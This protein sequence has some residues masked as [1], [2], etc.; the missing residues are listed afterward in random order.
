MANLYDIPSKPAGEKI[1]ISHTGINV[2]SHL[3]EHH[4]GQGKTPMG[5]GFCCGYRLMDRTKAVR[6]HQKHWKTHCH[7]K[8]CIQPIWRQWGAKSSRPFHKKKITGI[9]TIM[10]SFNHILQAN[11]DTLKKCRPSRRQWGLKAIA[12]DA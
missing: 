9:N 1:G 11:I 2:R 10:T 4:A 6:R 8:I 5:Y 7:G 12:A 3:I